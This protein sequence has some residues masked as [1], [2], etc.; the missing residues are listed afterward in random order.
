MR[1]C[2]FAMFI[3]PITRATYALDVAGRENLSALDQPAII[4]CNHNLHLDQSLALRAMPRRFRQRVAIA[5]AASD[6]FGNRVRGFGSALLGNAFPFAKA[7]VGVRDS[8]EYC[9]FM[10][11]DGWHVLI[12][13]EG[14]LTELGPMQPFKPGVALLAREADAPVLP[15]RIDV[16]KPSLW[17]GR[18]WRRLRGRVRVTFGPPTAVPHG[19]KLVEATR[20]LELAVREA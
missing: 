4:V 14:M 8:L 11:E 15:V 7:G 16:E 10:L 17:D 2:L 5:A 13:P 6:I 1:R 20:M 3:L 9:Q 18:G 19:T 12:F